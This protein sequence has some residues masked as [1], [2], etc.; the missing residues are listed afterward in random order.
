ME[1][2][3]NQGIL[4]F[5]TGKTK[6]S[7]SRYPSS[8]ELGFWIQH[9]WFVTWDLRGQEPYTQE[10]LQHPGVN[11][12]FEQ[13]NSRI[14]GIDRRKSVNLLQGEGQ[15]VGVLF[16]PGAF[17]SFFKTP[18]ATLTDHTAP[19]SD[20]FPI[21]CRAFEEELFSLEDHGKRI[22]M[23]ERLLMQ[24]VPDRDETVDILNDVINGI[25][26]DREITQVE[27]VVERFGMTKRT[28]QRL[29]RQYIGVSPK[30]VIQ[31]YRMHEAGELIEQGLD[32][33]HL[34]MDLGYTDQAHF[35]KDFKA[36]VGKSP[37][38]YAKINRTL[39]RE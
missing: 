4:H 3:P 13:G 9:Y 28:L 34:A 29:F 22:E 39:P 31:R 35:S 23:V 6:F 10:V 26:K 27:H 32:L 21:N 38:E 17:Y 36:A 11:I 14:S 25:V 19:L 37:R 16:R 20:Y 8:G 1:R 12:V 30:W 24:W 2:N 7:I 33:A 15:I 5:N 18:A